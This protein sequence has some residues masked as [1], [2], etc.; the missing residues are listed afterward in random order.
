[1]AITGTLSSVQMISFRRRIAAGSS[2][3]TSS[4]AVGR[5]GSGSRAVYPACSTTVTNS[6]GVTPTEKLTLAFSVE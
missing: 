3:G 1:M 4:S 2:S 6:S 5:G